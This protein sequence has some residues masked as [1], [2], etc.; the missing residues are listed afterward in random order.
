MAI[1]N[2]GVPQESI[3]RPLLFLVYINDLADDLLSNAKLFADDKYLSSV[4]HNVDTSANELNNDLYQINK[5]A[6]QWKASFNQ[7]PSKH[8][9]KIVG[10][11]A[12][13]RISKRV[14]QETK[15]H[16]NFRKTIISYLLIRTSGGKKCLFFGNFDVLCF[17]ETPVLRFALLSYYPRNIFC[18]KTK[19][20]IFCYILIIALS[21]KPYIQNNL[22][23]FL[24][25]D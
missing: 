18:R 3:L 5:W 9:Q 15:A 12:K 14:F 11:G 23:Y 2:T 10:N 17:F 20:I 25:L 21:C 4:I 24:M 1:V 6:F 19:K 16:Q 13:V 22:A 8:A 7:D